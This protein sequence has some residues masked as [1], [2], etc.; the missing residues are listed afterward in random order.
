MMNEEIVEIDQVEDGHVVLAVP[1]L[2]LI[3]MGRT[4]EEA[5]AW[6][7]S[8]IAHRRHDSTRR[9]EPSPGMDAAAQPRNSNAA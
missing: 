7:I 9:A 8:A 1:S 3:V 6:A 5:R 4:L 2:R